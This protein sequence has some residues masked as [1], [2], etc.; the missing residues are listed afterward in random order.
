MPG[1]PSIGTE[2]FD[3]VWIEEV[4]GSLTILKYKIE[5][6]TVTGYAYCEIKHLSIDTSRS[7][8]KLNLFCPEIGMYGD[9]EMNGRLIVLPVEGNGNFTLSIY[10]Y[11]INF[12]V[13]YK[14][15]KT[16]DGKEYM[17]IKDY[18][19]EATTERGGVFYFDNLFNGRKDLADTVLKFANENSIEV[20]HEFQ[21]PILAV[22]YKK[23]MKNLNK[24][25]KSMPMEHLF[26]Q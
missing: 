3:P 4:D 5:N 7:N 22:T 13:D 1:I 11:D 10:S 17:S 15:V 12:D 19:F 9:Y 8:F 23:F 18:N 16:Y 14:V 6:A 2:N 20:L 26:A 21:R 25:L 24:F